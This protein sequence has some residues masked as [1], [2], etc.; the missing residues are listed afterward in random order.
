[1]TH[2]LARERVGTTAA[3]RL[4]WTRCPWTRPG[5]CS[6]PARTRWRG[7]ARPSRRG[8]APGTGGRIPGTV[9]GGA[10]L[11]QV[12]GARI[13]DIRIG[14]HVDQIGNS[15]G[16]RTSQGGRDPLRI[17][18][19]LPCPTQCCDHLVVA[20]AWLEIGSNIV[21]VQALHGM[22]FQIPDSV[23]AHDK[24]NGQRMAD[25]RVP[26]RKSRRVESPRKPVPDGAW[27]PR[28]PQQPRRKRPG[29]AM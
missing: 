14:Y 16:E 1:M 6:L 4:A 23:V 19:R 22:L 29:R 21:A 7:W 2:T 18:H 27:P 25:Q 11:G 20:T 28:Q 5:E 3:G 8:G 15:R 9:P 24:D 12:G 10:E 26:R 17:G 13:D